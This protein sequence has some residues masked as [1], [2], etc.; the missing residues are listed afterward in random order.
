MAS[1]I[2]C[3]VC[4][5]RKCN[6]I[7]IETLTSTEERKMIFDYLEDF[8][9]KGY[10]IY[11]LL[12]LE[13]D[14]SKP[15]YIRNGDVLVNRF[16]WFITKDKMEFK[17]DTIINDVVIHDEV[18]LTCKNSTYFDISSDGT[19]KDTAE[20]YGSLREIPVDQYVEKEHIYIDA[21]NKWR[22]NNHEN[23]GNDKEKA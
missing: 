9:N 17:D 4:T 12:H 18:A 5:L 15:S 1:K 2:D 6:G 13:N 14:W 21:M 11:G 7:I 8:K 3:A 23:I 20:Y 22:E 10:H 16:G 19:V